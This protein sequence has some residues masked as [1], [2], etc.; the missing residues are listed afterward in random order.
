VTTSFYSSFY[1]MR[2][3]GKKQDEDRE[4]LLPNF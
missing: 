4:N 2:K 3:Q 1:Y